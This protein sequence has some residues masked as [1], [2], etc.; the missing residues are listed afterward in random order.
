MRVVAKLGAGLTGLRRDIF[1]DPSPRQPTR[2]G[3]WLLAVLVAAL[4]TALQLARMW[5]SGPLH[6]I[7]AEDGSQWLTSATTRGLGTDLRTPY[8]GYLQTSSRLLGEL[9]SRLPVGAFAVGMAV[10]GS[11]LVSGCALVVWATSSTHVRSSALRA[12]LAGSLVLA[13]NAGVEMYANVTNAI[14]FELYTCFWLVL[15]RPGRVRTAGLGALGLCLAAL[16]TVATVL[17]LPV[18]LARLAAARDRRDAILLVGLPL[19]LAV[20]ASPLALPGRAQP[21]A[22][23]NWDLLPAYAQRV[24]APSA[25]GD[26]IAGTAWTH[27]GVP[28]EVIAGA[29][30]LSAIVFGA[31]RSSPRAR[32]VGA[33]AIAVSLLSFFATGYE[34]AAGPHLI[35]RT[36]TDPTYFTRYSVVPSLLLIAAAIVFIDNRVQRGVRFSG[37][38]VAWTLAV[39]VVSFPIGDQSLRGSPVYSQAL[40]VARAQCTGASGFAPVNVSPPY[41]TPMRLP[42]R[43]LEKG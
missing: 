18:W 33:L 31:A 42:C 6:S 36:G 13:P 14:W 27:I 39:A 20:Q 28:V 9:V 32:V 24:I 30:F 15:W 4:F 19:G 29:A 2:P 26:R 22:H 40:R 37:T 38:V 8:D 12:L 11:L 21:P 34:R 5:A 41:F 3:R 35:W 25:L 23:W 16:S 1:S 7:W 17:L 43:R 10:A